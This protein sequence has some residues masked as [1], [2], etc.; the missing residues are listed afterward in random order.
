[1]NPSKQPQVVF[2]V[3]IVGDGGTG[4]TTFVKRHETGEYRKAY[5]PTVGADVTPI[6]FYTNRGPVGLETWDTAGQEKFGVL[7]DAY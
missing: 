2:K 7:R 6:P 3:V 5:V 1:M 4:K